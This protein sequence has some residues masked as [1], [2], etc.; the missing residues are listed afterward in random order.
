MQAK[1][2]NQAKIE[3]ILNF[4]STDCGI[5]EKSASY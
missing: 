5:C 3:E 2:I 1:S 4:I